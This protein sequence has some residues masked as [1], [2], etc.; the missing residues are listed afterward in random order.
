MRWLT[1]LSAH[2]GHCEVFA[3]VAVNMNSKT[4]VGTELLN[5]P[6]HEPGVLP[7]WT[8]EQ[9][10]NLIIAAS[11]GTRAQDMFKNHG[12]KVIVGAPSEGK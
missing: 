8:A 12:V 10:A 9:D 7:N 4:I 6:P 3:F 2:F 5:P 11:M 1:A